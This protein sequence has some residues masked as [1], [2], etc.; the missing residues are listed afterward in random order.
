MAPAGSGWTELV[1]TASSTPTSAAHVLQRMKLRMMT[2]RTFTPAS[3]APSRLPPTATV[4]RPQ[5]VSVSRICSTMM[6]AS[7]QISSE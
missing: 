7:A 6:I 4:Y 5:R 1:R 3:A 2:S